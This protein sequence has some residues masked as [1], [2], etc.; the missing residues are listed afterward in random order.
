MHVLL[1]CFML[2]FPTIV[3]AIDCTSDLANLTVNQ[4]DTLRRLARNRCREAKATTPGDPA[5]YGFD[6]NAECTGTPT[7]ADMDIIVCDLGTN[8][9]QGESQN[10][11][12]QDGAE[13]GRK[14]P[15]LPK[16]TRD[17]MKT[18]CGATCTFVGE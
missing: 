8:K 13:I 1:I 11:I 15:Q 4:E 14:F 17:A 7:V 2:I 18:A 3:W 16:A 10:L 5:P 9:L 12:D 6:D